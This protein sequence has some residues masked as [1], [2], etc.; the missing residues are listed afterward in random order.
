[1]ET[2]SPEI[3]IIVPALN[4][5]ENLPPLAQRV[6]AAIA[7]RS[8]ELLIVDDDSR[9][10]TSAV[11]AELAEA[12]PL[13]LI[14]RK[15]ATDGLGGAVLRGMAEARGETF[16]VMDADLQ[17]P[18]EM[19]PKLLA[20]LDAGAEFALGSR[21]VPGG[22]TAGKW[23]AVRKLNSWVATLLA[24][25]FAGRVR[26]PM[27][28]FF[29]LRRSTF[30]RGTRL[31]PLGY[32]IGL[33]L[34]CKCRV[35]AV[36]EVPIHFALREHGESKLTVAEQFRY[37]E[38]LSRLYD[39]TFPRLSAYAKFA[40]VVGLGWLCGLAV[41]ELLVDLGLRPP[42]AIAVS[43]AANV[44][45]TAAFHLRYVRVQRQFLVVERPWGAFWATCFAEWVACA[46]V[47]GWLWQRLNH[48]K[49][50]EVFLASYAATVVVRYILRKELGQDLRGL[51]RELRRDELF[52]DR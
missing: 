20:A 43:Y 9:D 49:I 36:T 44:A 22:S 6:A 37:L 27:S 26:D 41:T 48:P 19:I 23:G 38:H 31:A 10:N 34:M 17:H 4:E 50:I 12:Y 24:R 15:N 14:V 30:E 52:P 35:A 40:I 29:A 7:G 32:K 13:R 5:A 51:R 33:E 28:G 25:P 42:A 16:V 39:F 47:A 1:M 21:Y 45:L 18:P 46:A 3:S 2:P 8:Y 11:C